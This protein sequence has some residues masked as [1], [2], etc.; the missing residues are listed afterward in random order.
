MITH[1]QRKTTVGSP[2]PKQS[3]ITQVDVFNACAAVRDAGERV[4]FSR[5]YKQIGNKGS[6]K[7]VQNHI[8]E[9]VR[10][11][12][13]R[14]LPGLPDEFSERIRQFAVSTWDECQAIARAELDEERRQV[15]VELATGR[16]ACERVRREASMQVNEAEL[17]VSTIKASLAATIVETAHQSEQIRTQEADLINLREKLAAANAKTLGLSE[18]L[19]RTRQSAEGYRQDM[20]IQ[21]ER[22]D[23]AYRGLEKKSLAD[24][25]TA[26]AETRYVRSDL[27]KRLANQTEAADLRIQA[28]AARIVELTNALA[29]AQAE[30]AQCKIC[31]EELKFECQ[32]NIN[33][34][35]EA[36]TELACANGRMRAIEEY[37]QAETERADR[38][39]QELRLLTVATKKNRE[40]HR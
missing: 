24:I 25:E 9:W 6:A 19:A 10:L 22:L 21:V 33:L 17:Q 12:N 34:L 27:E 28:S 3:E 14:I 37:R 29:N 20:Q 39:A 4:S 23:E 40:R 36:R 26:R 1:Q 2:V 8:A 30:L 35:V 16:A 5:V 31:T 13:K 32:N 18:E 15:A 11:E 7:V 38:L